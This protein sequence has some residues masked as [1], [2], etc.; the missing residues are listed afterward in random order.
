MN[1]YRLFFSIVGA[2]LALASLSQP[3]AAEEKPDAVVDRL[4]SPAWV[5]RQGEKQ[6]LSS[7]VQLNNRD[8]VITGSDAR[9][10]IRLKDGAI[11]ALGAD[12]RMEINALGVRGPNIF[13]AALDVQQGA[14][15]YSADALP[16]TRQSHA[17]NLRIGAIVASSRGTDL[18]WGSTDQTGDRVCLLE[19]RIAVLHPQAEPLQMTEPLRCYVARTDEGDAPPSVEAVSSEQ[20]A[21]FAAQTDMRVESGIDDT[22]SLTARAKTPAR[23]RNA[24]SDTATTQTAPRFA[25]FPVAQGGRWT[26]DLA[27]VE[28]ETEALAL[29]DRVRAAGYSGRIKPLA[30]GGGYRYAVRVTAFASR[31]DAAAVAAKMTAVLERTL[32]ESASAAISQR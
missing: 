14:V 22:P 25:Q 31:D 9:V 8:R 13:T 3:S 15:R 10:R 28:S 29:Y 20:F 1:R 26:V 17:I 2:L 16:G 7:G 32:R 4:R 5:E 11:V 6:A 30:T 24:T 27:T 23:S 12:A 18:L 21:V 19:G